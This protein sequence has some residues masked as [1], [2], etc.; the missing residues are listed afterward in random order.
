[1]FSVNNFPGMTSNQHFR[2]NPVGFN[3]EGFSYLISY[4]LIFLWMLSFI[5]LF[6]QIIKRAVIEKDGAGLC[7]S[8]K[9]Y[10]RVIIVRKLCLL[11]GAH[12]NTAVILDILLY[13]SSVLILIDK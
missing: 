13:A 10:K 8:S 6:Y 3:K 11:E 4:L 12:V 5:Y 9:I 7:R 2:L 1:M